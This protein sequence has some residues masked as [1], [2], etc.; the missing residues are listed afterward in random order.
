MARRPR[1]RSNRSI[2]GTNTAAI[3]GIVTSIVTNVMR[4]EITSTIE[5]VDATVVIGVADGVGATRCRH[6]PRQL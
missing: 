4:A 1:H 6:R 5:M 3:A 2:D